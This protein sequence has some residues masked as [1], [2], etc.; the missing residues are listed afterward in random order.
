[1]FGPVHYL[2]LIEQKTAALD[3][4]APLQAWDLPEVFATL[5]RLM[6]ARMGQGGKA[7]VRPGP[8]AAG[9]IPAQGC[10]SCGPRCL[11][12]G[13]DRLRCGQAPDAVPDRAPAAAAQPRRLSL[14]AQGHGGDH[15]GP[16][17]HEPAVW[18]R[19][20]TDTPQVLLGHHLSTGSPITSTSL[21]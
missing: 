20:M 12:I 6:E 4:A 5:R 19:Y 10:R 15:L 13:R 7:R 17:L 18:S 2:P 14:P 21:R 11:A 1:M 8:S 9:D 16:E 3:Q